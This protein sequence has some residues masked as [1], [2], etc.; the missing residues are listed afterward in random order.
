METWF[1]FSLPQNINLS[2][3]KADPGIVQLGSGKKY[4]SGYNDKTLGN[5]ESD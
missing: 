4:E 1:A 5:Y 2:Q 3:A